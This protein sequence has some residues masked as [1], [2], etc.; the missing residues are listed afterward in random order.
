MLTVLERLSKKN[1]AALLA[2]TRRELSSCTRCPIYLTSPIT[3]FGEGPA[4]AK[5]MLVGEQPGDREDIEGRPFVGPAGRLLDVALQEAG[6]DRRRVYVSNAVK[7]FKHELRGK[8]RIHKK[9]TNGEI[10]SCR[11]WLDR[12]RAAVKPRLIVAMGATAVRGV[13]GKTVPLGT[14]RGEVRPLDER[15][16]VLVTVHPSFLIR[17]RAAEG[18]YEEEYARFVADLRLAARFV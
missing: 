9:P 11:W 3:V 1:A 10:D 5:V 6:I 12:E 18:G 2:E 4:D 15:T 7:R 16:Q 13:L 14:L 17:L 8:K